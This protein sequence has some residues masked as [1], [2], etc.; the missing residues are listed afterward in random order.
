[1]IGPSFAAGFFD[2]AAMRD[3]AK[4][5][6]DAI[7]HIP[8][9]LRPPGLDS[10]RTLANLS[11]ADLH[12]YESTF[13]KMQREIFLDQAAMHEAY[14]S[15][16]T[17]A[18][19][20]M[21]AA[22]TIDDA[23]LAAWRQ[24]DEGARTSTQTL[25]AEGNRGLLLREQNNI[26][27]ADYAAMYSH[28]PTGPAMT[29]LMTLIGT[30]SIPGAHGYAEVFPLEVGI[31]TP[32]PDRLGT[33]SHIGTPDNIFGIPIPNVGVDIP[34]INVDN[35][36]QGTVIITTPFPDGNIANFNDRWNLITTDTLPAYQALLQNPNDVAA[37]VRS[38]IGARIDANRLTERIDDIIRHLEDWSVDFQQ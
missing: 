8:P 29:Y 36:V 33:P 12:F 11:E 13:L 20:Q 38:D 19:E 37:I 25:I 3:G 30:P 28:Q 31:D 10:L 6:A 18:L 24:I 35:P 32:G 23:T 9:A 34:S 2:L 17:P 5:L 21:R 16:G 7:D 27:G 15:G 1:M 22:G 4:R 14:V 26:I